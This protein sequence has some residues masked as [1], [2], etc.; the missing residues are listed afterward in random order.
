MEAIPREAEILIKVTNNERFLHDLA[1]CV[2]NKRKKTNVCEE[3]D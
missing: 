3:I 1:M 2:G